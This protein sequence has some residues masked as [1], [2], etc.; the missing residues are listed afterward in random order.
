MPHIPEPHNTPADPLRACLTLLPQHATD[1]ILAHLQQVI[2]YE[3]VIGIMGKS[4][5]G[6]SSLCNAL[7]QQP[8][9]LTSDL[10]ACTVSVR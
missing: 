2:H 5:A 6:K 1:R 4:G 10:T 8:V 9:C 3:P 7:F